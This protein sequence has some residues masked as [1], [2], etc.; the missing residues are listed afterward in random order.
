[1]RDVEIIIGGRVV[2]SR[3]EL[4]NLTRR[5]DDALDYVALAQGV[6]RQFPAHGFAILL[7]LNALRLERGGQLVKWDLVADRDVLQCGVQL[8]IGDVEADLLGTLHLDFLQDQP[9]E[10]LLA[11]HAR[12]WQ[13]DFLFDQALG[14]RVE[15]AVHLGLQHQAVVD[16]RRNAIKNFTMRP[17]IPGLCVRDP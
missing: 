1:M 4:V 3:E 5:D 16:D 6:Q 11:Q 7:V 14:D 9:L 2:L 17:Q 10:H 8:L 13:S 15:L 12:T